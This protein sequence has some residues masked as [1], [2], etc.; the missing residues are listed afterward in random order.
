V[1]RAEPPSIAAVVLAAG[2]SSRMGRPKMVLPFEGGTLLSS[3][4]RAI[5]VPRVERVVVVLGPEAEEVRRGAGLP[6]DPRVEVVVNPGWAEGLSSS[7]RVG[8]GACRGAAAAAVTLGDEP[9]LSATTVN[10]VLSA[11]RPGCPL[12]VPRSGERWGHPVVLGRE[13]WPEVLGLRGDVGAREVI[14]AHAGE[15]VFVEAPLA[16]DVDTEADYRALTGGGALDGG[17]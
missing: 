15:A 3:A 5:L 6:A 12:V 7:L 16:D 17:C 14:R 8:V 9:R 1:G 10:L 2:A 13:L 11:W 4:V